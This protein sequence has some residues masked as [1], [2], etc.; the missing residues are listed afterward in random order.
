MLSEEFAKLQLNYENGGGMDLESSNEG[1]EE[2]LNQ[3]PVEAIPDPKDKAGAADLEDHIE[4]DEDGEY[5]YKRKI[6]N[7][8][9]IMEKKAD[10]VIQSKHKIGPIKPAKYSGENI[11]D[12]IS[13]GTDDDI[14]KN[15]DDSDNDS[16]DSKD[17]LYKE[18]NFQEAGIP[19]ESEVTLQGHTK[20]VNAIAIDHVGVR[21]FTG[22]NDYKLHLWDLPNLDASL[23]AFRVLEPIETQPVKTL[24]FNYKGNVCLVTGGNVRPKIV[25]REGRSEL[26]F[27][28]GDMYIRDQKY[29]RGHTGVVTSG[30]WHPTNHHELVTSSLDGSVR[31]FDTTL[32]TI[33]VEQQLPSRDVLKCR[34]EK[35][36]PTGVWKATVFPD[37]SK[38][39]AAGEDGSYFIFNGNNKTHV[40]DLVYRS[41]YKLEVTNLLGFQD[42]YRF[43]SR[44]QDNTMKMFDIRKFE[45]P[46]HT[47]YEL[48]NNHSHTG[49]CF[50]PDEKYILTG[51]SNTKTSPGCLHFIDSKSLEEITRV[52]LIDNKVTAVVWSS[53]LNQI[54]VGAGNTVKAYFDPKISHNG[55]MHCVGRGFKK[56]T[57]DD[58]QYTKP[59]M[60]PH[61]LAIFNK[62]ERYKRKN[63]ETIRTDNKLSSKPE[64]PLTGPGKG[65]KVAGPT[66][67]T[68]N[69]MR[70]VYSTDLGRREDPVEALKRQAAAAEAN[71]VFIDN[72]YKVTQPVKILDWTTDE[73][74]EKRLMKQFKKCPRCGLKLC[75]CYTDTLS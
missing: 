3:E 38:I 31:I 34:D 2:E 65:G 7:W 13:Y 32:N 17:R 20:T 57:A 61:A 16:E 73:H 15:D 51:S 26:E 5:T 53:V 39:I 27:V 48:Y 63:M 30:R 12:D 23:R 58:F 24:D 67:V 62:D 14:S 37:G 55:V 33:G 52:P 71:P 1:N 75:H 70:V 59:I 49:M 42:G 9:N 72:A 68:Q 44:N 47:W 56:I 6:I 43:L 29:T 35:G 74:E 64:M 21:M 25:N 66:T 4:K 40:H 45:R 8:R 50:S 46:V 18:I 11:E 10:E 36:L 22:G 54:F 28:K 19:F 60:T 41:P 69:L